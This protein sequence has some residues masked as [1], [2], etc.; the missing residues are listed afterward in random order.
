MIKTLII[1]DEKGSADRLFHFLERDHQSS[2]EVLGWVQTAKEALDLLNQKTVD[3]IFLDVELGEQTGFEVLKAAPKGEFQV[4]FTTAHQEYA[5]QAIKHA[6][7]DYLLKPIDR[8]ELRIAIEKVKSKKNGQG[9][10]SLEKLLRHLHL[11]DKIGNKIALPSL[12]GIEYISVEEIMRCQADVNYTHFFLKNGRK[13]T[14][15]KTLKEYEI[16]LLPHGF[17]RVH[18]SHLVNLAEVK[19]Y[20]KGKGGSLVLSDGTEVEVASRRKEDLIQVL[21]SG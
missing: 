3:L 11:Q 15:S 7:L 9:K 2:I 17:F 5:L 20:Q 8:E 10:E 6:A 14:V 13:I 4:V 1:E 12:I 21:G 19:L 18:N 16:Q